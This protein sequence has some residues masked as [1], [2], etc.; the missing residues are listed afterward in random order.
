MK[1]TKLNKSQIW[2][3]VTA[4]VSKTIE[5]KLEGTKVSDLA[6]VLAADVLAA[7]DFLKPKTGGGTSNK[8]NE[9]GNVYCNYFEA[10]LPANEFHKKL[11]KADEKGHRE[12]VFKA[13]SIKAENIIRRV[14]T[15][16]NSVTAMAT[17]AF[18]K[19]LIKANELEVIL[20]RLEEACDVK[21]LTVDEIPSAASVVGLEDKM[22]PKNREKFEGEAKGKKKVEAPI[23]TEDFDI[24]DE[25]AKMDLEKLADEIEASE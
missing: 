17:D 8:V 23:S 11:K 4:E 5:S 19:K 10:Y 7:I 1:T 3:M 21:Y 2:D 9:A 20:D 16:N 22:A 15:L 24:D 14:K 25:V 12:Q 13:N 18:H 6:D